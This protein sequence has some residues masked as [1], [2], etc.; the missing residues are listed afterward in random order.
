MIDLQLNFISNPTT[1]RWF[2]IL[3]FIERNRVFTISE[4]AEEFN[5]SQRTIANDLRELKEHFVDCAIF[6][7]SSSGFTFEEVSLSL[8]KERKKNYWK[9]RFYSN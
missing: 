6:N 9:M 8:Y 7:S 4:L 2:N 1:F 3:N 5:M